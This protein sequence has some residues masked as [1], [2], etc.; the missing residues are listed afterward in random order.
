MAKDPDLSELHTDE[1]G[2]HEF[3]QQFP[4]ARTR[5]EYLRECFEPVEWSLPCTDNVSP[6]EL[7][8]FPSIKA[9]SDP[10]N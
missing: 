6:S 7:P 1:I 3:I 9:T 8:A 5:L 4:Q 2:T 10:S